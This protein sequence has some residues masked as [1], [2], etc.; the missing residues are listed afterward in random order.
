VAGYWI[1]EVKSLDEAVEWAKQCPNPMPGEQGTLEIRPTYA[2]E[3]FNEIAPK[4][5]FE[6]EA[7]LRKVHQ[8]GRRLHC[9]RHDQ[10]FHRPPAPV[11]DVKPAWV[12]CNLSAPRAR[13]RGR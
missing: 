4:K 12:L 5:E 8:I 1:W 2:L 3:E 7:R 11:S 9:H 13:L 6:R 10:A